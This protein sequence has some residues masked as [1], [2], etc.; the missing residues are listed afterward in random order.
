MPILKKM[1]KPRVPNLCS[2]ENSKRAG[3]SFLSI[4]TSKSQEAQVPR[5][6]MI[7]RTHGKGQGALPGA[8]LGLARSLTSEQAGT[9]H[10]SSLSP[11]RLGKEG[12]RGSRRVTATSPGDQ[13]PSPSRLCPIPPRWEV[14]K[15]VLFKC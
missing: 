11:P 4:A 13:K 10:R 2:Q 5:P 9:P 12:G 7:T 15:W 1:E 6:A 8:S 3:H 14:Y